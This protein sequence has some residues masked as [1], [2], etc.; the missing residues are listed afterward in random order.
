MDLWGL[1]NKGKVRG[2]NQDVFEILFNEDK[3]VAVL[4][5]CDGMGGAKSGNVASAV[6][7]EAFMQ[8]M[9]EYVE[10]NGIQGDVA[11]R[12][13]D[14]V[15]AANSAVYK[16]SILGFEY[17]GMGTTLTAA[18][19]TD[20]G[21]VV[22]NIGD[23]RVYHITQSGINQV[24]KDHS[25]V[26]D[27]IDRGELTREA[28]AKHPKK[29]LITRALGTCFNEEPDVFNI[30]LDKGDYFLL[31][32]DGLTNLVSDDE[33]LLELRKGNSVREICDGLMD[34]ALTRGAPDNVTVVIFQK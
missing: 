21:E 34:M 22:V 28:A 32:S 23:S 33:I 20:D 2:Q 12:I 30:K 11:M 24:T 19:S 29:N 3:N 16:K 10:N 18:I 25:V 4:V 15:L 1:T 17:A 9:G 7:A 5:V 13:A 14:A 31:C 6:A 26:E 8:Y 27:M